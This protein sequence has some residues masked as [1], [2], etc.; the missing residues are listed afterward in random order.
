[1]DFKCLKQYYDRRGPFAIANFEESCAYWANCLI[2]MV[3][4][5]DPEVVVLS[6]GVIQWGAELTDRLE[7]V[8]KQRAWTPWG[9]LQFRL[10]HDPEQ[11]VLLGLHALCVEG[12]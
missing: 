5:Y 11:S 9:N 1:M 12:L 8:V 2:A 10:A 6:G 7:Q 3:Y 4:A